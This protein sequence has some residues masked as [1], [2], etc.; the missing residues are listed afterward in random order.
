M[1]SPSNQ[2]QVSSI[3]TNQVSDPPFSLDMFQGAASASLSG[4]FSLR[5]GPGP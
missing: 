1:L 5:T 2:Y 3:S 4:E